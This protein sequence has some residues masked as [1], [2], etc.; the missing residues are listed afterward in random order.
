MTDKDIKRLTD[1]AKEL[2]KKKYT[3][4]EALASLV[5]A[6]I[7]IKKGNPTKPYRDLAKADK[8]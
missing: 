7:L 4:E 5:S 8:R 2:L 3:K 1:L 6:G